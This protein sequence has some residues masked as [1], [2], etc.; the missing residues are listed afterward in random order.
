GVAHA[1]LALPSWNGEPIAASEVTQLQ[2]SLSLGSDR[3]LNTF[4]GRRVANILNFVASRNSANDLDDQMRTLA[5]N[6]AIALDGSYALMRFIIWAMP[7]LGFLGTV[8]GI[9]AAIA[10]ID[11]EQ[12]E[13][14][15]AGAVTEGLTQAFD[16]TAL[17][18]GLTLVAMFF[19]SMVEKLEQSVLERVDEYVDKELAHR[20][21]RS[22]LT[23]TVGGAITAAPNLE[24]L[25][26]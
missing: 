24:L 7:I 10:G 25:L 20:F 17:A 26:E 9:T 16:A 21:Q 4:L 18:L 19:N 23:T 11:P 5:D 12:L 15:G 1:R 8:L 3:L 6:D 13:K 14:G 2:Q 22:S